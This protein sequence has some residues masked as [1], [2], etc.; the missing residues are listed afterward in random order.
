VIGAMGL[1]LLELQLRNVQI[2]IG[3]SVLDIGRTLPIILGALF[4]LVVIVFPY[5]IVGTFTRWRL[6]RQ[7][8]SAERI[9]K[10][11][12]ALKSVS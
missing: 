1:R 11:A 7:A 8:R 9:A 2:A 3:E 10:Q 4:I 6:N 5:G 12:E